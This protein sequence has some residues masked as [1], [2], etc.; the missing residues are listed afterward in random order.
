MNL[1]LFV[2][3]LN[4]HDEH[5]TKPRSLGMGSL[6][7]VTV[8][9]SMGKHMTCGMIGRWKRCSLDCDMHLECLKPITSGKSTCAI[10]IINTKQT[11]NAPLRDIHCYVS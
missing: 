3:K 10:E 2:E 9:V 8:L 6:C 11:M 1:D 7:V 5:S 4:F